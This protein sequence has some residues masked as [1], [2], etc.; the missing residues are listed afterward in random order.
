[1]TGADLARVER[2]WILIGSSNALAS[3]DWRHLARDAQMVILAGDPRLPLRDLPNETIRLGYVSIGEAD[4][5][6]GYWQAVRD[7]SYLVEANPN[8]PE[9]MRVDVRDRHWQEILLGQEIPRLMELGFDGLMLDTI[10]TAPYLEETDPARFGGSRQA[11]SNL[12]AAIRRTFPKAVLVA[13]GTSGLVDVA[14]H[15]DG[16]V[17]EGVFATYDFGRRLYR[18][19]TEEERTWKLAQIDKAR[20]VAPRP[21]FTIEYADVGDIALAQTAADESRRRGFKPY[22]G[23]RD[24]NTLP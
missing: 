12:V 14:P 16:F 21:V 7:Q 19:T 9:N 11:L 5:H 3:V 10:D 24:L 20:Q 22:V 2:W 23:V 4:A 13:N 17:V 8:W 6:R 18:P 15:V 1:M